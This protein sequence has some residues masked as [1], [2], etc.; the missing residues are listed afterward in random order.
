MTSCI[1]TY[2]CFTCLERLEHRLTINY[3]WRENES[4]KRLLYIGFKNLKVSKQYK[5][6]RT[7]TTV[8]ESVMLASTVL[9]YKSEDKQLVYEIG[10]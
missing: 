2:T 4:S 8:P 10:N 3:T 1:Y 6:R 5:S 9:A 7:S